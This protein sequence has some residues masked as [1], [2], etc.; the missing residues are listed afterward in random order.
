MTHSIGSKIRRNVKVLGQKV[1]QGQRLGMKIGRGLDVGGRKVGKTVRRIS[2]GISAV[3]PF[4][5]G[6]PLNGGATIARDIALGVRAGAKE[7]RNAGRALERVSH[8]DLAK[9]ARKRIENEAYQFA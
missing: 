4:L 7:V 9:E 5:E 2:D 1:K 8:R 6:T 3:E